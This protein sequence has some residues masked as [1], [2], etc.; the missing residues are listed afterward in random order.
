MAFKE[1]NSLETEQTISLGGT[2]KKTGKQ[3]PTR[4]EGYYL[5]NRKIED[6]K[7]KSG[8]TYIHVFQT[9]KGNVGVW[10]KTDLDRKLS[11]VTP[12]TMT[13]VSFVGMAPTKNGEMYKYKAEIDAD[14]VIEVVG[15]PVVG[16]DVDTEETGYSDEIVESGTFEDEDE[17]QEIQAA[18]IERKKR[19]QDLLNGSKVKKA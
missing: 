19:V 16:Q 7:K 4:I 1:I 17:A 15:A 6:N 3:N 2:N 13:R 14:N 5:G 10:G 9:P 11:G 8:V 12:G 18:A